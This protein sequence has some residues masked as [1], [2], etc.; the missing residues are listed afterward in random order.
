VFPVYNNSMRLPA[1]WTGSR[2]AAQITFIIPFYK[3]V[4]PM[5]HCLSTF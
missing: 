1:W 5:G 4:D 2:Y 3:A